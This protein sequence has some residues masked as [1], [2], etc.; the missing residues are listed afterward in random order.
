[1]L[2][3]HLNIF[4]YSDWLSPRFQDNRY[5][6]MFNVRSTFNALHYTLISYTYTY[7]HLL[8]CEWTDDIINACT[9]FTNVVIRIMRVDES[10]GGC[11]SSKTKDIEV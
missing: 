10:K 3:K 6:F 11:N 7:I 4:Y 8:T 2:S 9:N 5:L 1:M